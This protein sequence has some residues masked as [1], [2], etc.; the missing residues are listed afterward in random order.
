[1]CGPG[2]IVDGEIT[3]LEAFQ[4]LENSG[5]GILLFSNTEK[6]IEGILTDPDMRRLIIKGI[7]LSSM[8][9]DHMNRNFVSWVK[10]EH[11]ENPISFMRRREIHHLPLLDSK[12]RFV[13]LISLD[14]YKFDKQ[15]NPVVLMAGGLGTR[16]RPFTEKCPKPLLELNG[17]PI[18]EHIL[19]RFL[20]SG[21]VNFFI[22][23]N[24]LGEMIEERFGDG[25]KWGCNITYL[26]EK[27]KL[28][29]AGALALLP[30]S[31]DNPIIVANGDVMTNV[32][33]R[34]LLDYHK[35]HEAV[36]T[37]C[38]RSY[39]VQIPFGV[40]EIADGQVSTIVEKPIKKYY[41]N[42]GIYCLNSGIFDL[43]QH[44]ESLDMPILID[45]IKAAKGSVFGFPIHE[46]WIDVGRKEDLERAKKAFD[47]E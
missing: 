23:V 27:E 18:L 35:R 45:R 40:V 3:L 32:D 47:D 38:V 14:R 15:T 17:K 5:G 12:R 8:A 36:A 25:S 2:I 13:D 42:A 6:V 21:F 37:M 44:G 20:E 28:G 39:E 24:F 9:R 46:D 16:L 26:R 10:S 43:I 11:E 34:N 19:E 7:E 31:L 29:T 1:M 4:Y 33:L 22:S 30:N 41:V